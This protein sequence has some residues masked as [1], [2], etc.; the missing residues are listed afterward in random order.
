[1]KPSEKTRSDLLR[2]LAEAGGLPERA[3]PAHFRDSIE[4]HL[5]FLP[6]STRDSLI[7][8]FQDRQRTDPARAAVWLEAMTGI[9]LKDYDGTPLSMAEWQELRDILADDAGELDMDILSYAMTLVMENKA[10]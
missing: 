7:Q 8:G 2:S 5:G 3:R 10:L 1:M 9:F 4:R 6:A